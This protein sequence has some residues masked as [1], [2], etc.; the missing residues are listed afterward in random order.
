[1]VRGDGPW[2]PRGLDFVL[3]ENGQEVAY[4]DGP[5]SYSTDVLARHAIDF[6]GRT[7]AAH[8]PFFLY[9]ATLVPHAPAVPAARHAA[10]FPGASAPRPPS[11][12]E[13]DATDKPVHLRDAPRLS[14]EQIR[15]IDESHANRL[16]SLLSLDELI[17]GVVETLRVHG[18]LD[19]TFLLVTS[20]HGW[21]QG[22]HRLPM[23]KE[24]PYEESIRVPFGV[25][26]PGVTAGRVADDL[27]L[28]VDLAP[29]V[30]DLA[31]AEV[32]PFVDGRS[33]VPVLRGEVG[34]FGRRRFLIEHSSA[35]RTRS[36]PGLGEMPEIPTYQA[37]RSRG[38]DEDTLYVEYVTG[39]RELYD[40]GADPFQIENRAVAGADH[41]MAVF[42]ARLGELRRCAAGSCRSIEEQ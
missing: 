21:H 7:A 30:A 24:T 19:T 11:F 2:S 27:V 35:G 26:A 28:N 32:P 34:A 12:D 31:G 36:Y 42:A 1:V 33:L 22:E 13:P 16:R 38:T 37:M 41:Q 29:T 10:A 9:L 6:R 25:I 15:A 17:A 5:D 20:D 8:I 3:N 40:L 23:G 39:E 4:E 18:V 14:P